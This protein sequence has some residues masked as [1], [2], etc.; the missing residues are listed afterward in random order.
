MSQQGRRKNLDVVD[1]D[2]LINKENKSTFKAAA[3]SMGLG[4]GFLLLIPILPDIG[5]EERQRGMIDIFTRL[6]YLLVGYSLAL[7]F[8]FFLLRPNIGL[9]KFILNWIV[10]PTA[11]LW[12]VIEGYKVLTG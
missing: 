5:N 7:A 11:G 3:Y 8:G 6:S 9:I 2:L 12:A 4:I 1:Q 10:I